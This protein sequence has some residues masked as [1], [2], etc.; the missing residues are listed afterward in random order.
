MQHWYLFPY[1]HSSISA[2]LWEISIEAL[3]KLLTTQKK[4]HFSVNQRLS[5]VLKS[6]REFYYCDG[7]GVSRTVLDSEKY[8]VS[9]CIFERDATISYPLESL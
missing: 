6:L 1:A 5:N 9:S 4:K 2:H 7:D 8:M 3:D